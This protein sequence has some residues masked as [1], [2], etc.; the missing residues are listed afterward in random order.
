MALIVGAPGAPFTVT[1][2][3]LD[4]VPDP[5]TFT[6]RRRIGY[7]TPPV[8]PLIVSGDAIETGERVIQVEPLLIEYS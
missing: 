7:S 4:C 5:A 3:A 6:A 1:F 2:E 8:R